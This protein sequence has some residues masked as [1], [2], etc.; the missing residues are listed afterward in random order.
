MEK[1][2]KYPIKFAV[3]EI[4]ERGPYEEITIG[5]IASRCYQLET[6][7]KYHAEGNTSASHKVIFP[8]KDILEFKNSIKGKR[9]YNGSH[10]N[11]R[12]VWGREEDIVDNLF[13]NYEEAHEKAVEQNINLRR[14][15]AM[16]WLNDRE[17]I[18]KI[19]E[20]IKICENFEQSVLTETEYM[21][22]LNFQ[23]T[24]NKENNQLVKK[25]KK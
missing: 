14:K 7:I 4:K 21:E 25:C 22:Q 20:N 24:S 18:E 19:I 9:P 17:K 15:Y 11:P 3:L 12:T 5:F 13:D 6:T 8:L 1:E 23:G 16:Y 2:L 10:I